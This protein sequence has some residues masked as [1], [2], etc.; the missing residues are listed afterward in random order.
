M[1]DFHSAAPRIVTLRKM[2]DYVQRYYV[3][4]IT[5]KQIASAGSVGRTTCASIFR[6]SLNQSP[7]EFVNDVRVRAAANLLDNEL[8]A[9]RHGQPN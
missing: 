1:R 7:I 8:A 3:R 2:I 6:E 4:P 9:Y 5:L